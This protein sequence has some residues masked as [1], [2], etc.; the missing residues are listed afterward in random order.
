MKNLNL[1]FA[2]VCLLFIS[3]ACNDVEPSISSLPVPTSKPYSI[4]R[5]GY[6]Y[7]RIPTMVITNSGTILAFAEGRRNGPE[8]EGDI[9]I[10]LKRST[11]KGKTWGP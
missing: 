10:V 11:D 3:T 4:N 8:D 5:E 1:I 7:F 9:D 6:A 2:W